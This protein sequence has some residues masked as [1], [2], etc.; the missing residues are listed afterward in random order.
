MATLLP[1][2]SGLPAAAGMPTLSFA[3][4]ARAIS[5]VFKLLP[6]ST[7]ASLFQYGLA[8]ADPALLIVRRWCIV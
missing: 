1:G 6:A 2:G 3:T 8:A 4:R 5:A 7:V